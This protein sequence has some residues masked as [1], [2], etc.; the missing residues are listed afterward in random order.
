MKTRG[1]VFFL[2]AASLVLFSAQASHAQSAS[3]DYLERI[4]RPDFAV[5]DP[6]EAGFVNISN[7]NLHLEIPMASL[8]QRG[9]VPFTV[10]L[11]YDSRIYFHFPGCCTTPWNSENVI[12][13]DG[14]WKVLIT[15]QA[16][17]AFCQHFVGGS[18]LGVNRGVSSFVCYNDGI[19]IGYVYQFVDWTWATADGTS[20]SFG[21]ETDVTDI[22]FP[23]CAVFER[24]SA[25]GY[26]GDGS[27]YYMV[28]ADYDRQVAVYDNKGVLVNGGLRDTN[29]NFH[30]LDSSGNVIDTLGR[31]PVIKTVNGNITYYDILNS[32]GTRSRFTIT[33]TTINASTAFGIPYV[34]EYSGTITVVQ[35]LTLPNGQ[36]YTFTYD[37]GTTAGNYGLLQSMTL[38]TGAQIQYGYSNFNDSFCETNRWLSSR[39]SSLGGT[40]TYTPALI[41][42]GEGCPPFPNNRQDG[43]QSVT[44]VKPNHESTVYT[45]DVPAGLGAWNT[46]TVYYDSSGNALKT[47]LKEYAPVWV[48]GTTQ[49][50]IRL[51]TSFPT[52]GGSVT[53]K[54]EYSYDN[55]SYGNV[56]EVREWDYYT[57]TPPATPTRVTDATYLAA[58]QT[59]INLNILNKPTSV[60]VKDGS[61]HIFAQTNFEYDNYTSGLV[62]SGAVQH[63]ASYGPSLTARGN[64]TAIQRWRNTDGA[65]LTTRSQYDDAGNVLST[66]D[67]L[68][69]T[70]TFS[71]ADSWGNS[72]CTPTGGSAAAY[73]TQITNP[74]NQITRSKYNSCTGTQSSTTDANSQTTTYSYDAL[75]RLIQTNLAGGGQTSVCYSDTSGTSCYNG[76][77]PLKVVTTTAIATGVNLVSTAVHDALGRLSQ[78][79]L[80]SD[81]DG[82]TYVDTTYDP[83]GRKATVSNPYR[84]PNDPGPTNGVTTFLYDALGRTCLV[85]PPDSTP[86][87]G[88]SCPT[89]APANDVFTS[90]VGNT[91]TVTDQAGKKR[92]S[93]SDGLGRLTQVFEDPAGHNYETDYTYDALDNLT[94]V[95]QH[96]G[97]TGTGCASPPSSDLTSPW[98]VRRFTYN[99]LSQLKS[100]TNP[101]SNTATTPSLST[102]ATTYTYDANGNLTSKVMPAQNQ[103]GTATVTLSYCYDALNRLTSKAYTQQS[104]PMPS[105]VATYSYDQGPASANPIGRRTGMVDPAGSAGWTYDAMG[106]ALTEQRTTNNITKN[107]VYTYNLDGSVASVVYP[108]LRT[109]TYTPGGAGR[110]LAAID[111]AHSINFATNAHYSPAGALATIQNGTNLNSTYIFNN[112]LQ[113]CWMYA[114]TGTPLPLST[115]SCTTTAAAA[116]LLDLKY[117]FNLGTSDNGNVIGITNNRNNTRTQIFTYDTLNRIASARTQSTT[118]TFCWGETYTYD[119]PNSSGAWGNLISISA[120]SGYTGCP[121]ESLNVTVTPQNQIVGDTYDAAGNLINDGLGHAYTYNPENQLLTAGGVTYTYDGDGKRV[122]KSSGTLYWYGMGGDSLVETNLQGNSATEYVFFGGK[123]I[124]RRG[125][126]GGLFYYVADHLGTSRLMFQAGQTNPCYNADFYPFGGER[127][128]NGS[129]G[130]PINS[131]PQNYKF[132]GKERDSESGLDN[133]GARYDS[134]AMGRFMS[135]DPDN[136]SGQ[137]NPDDPQSWNGYSYARNNPLLYTDPNGETYEI[138]TTDPGGQKQCTSISDAQFSEA[139]RSNGEGGLFL[140][141]GD[142]TNSRSVLAAHYHDDG[143]GH[144]VWVGDYN[145]EKDCSSGTCLYWNVKTQTWE[146]P[147]QQAQAPLA[148]AAPLAIGAGCL[149]A[150]PCGA[151]A[152]GVAALF[153]VTVAAIDTYQ[154]FSKGGSNQR[155]NRQAA[156]A[157][158]AAER[159]TGKKFTQAQI[160]RFHDL[161]QKQG[162]GYR[163][164]VE[165]AVAV[166]EGRL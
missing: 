91:T 116:S 79:Q 55:Y 122:Q 153:L 68:N 62:P 134:S 71:Y 57:G 163:E 81:P 42:Q 45:F 28:V 16:D 86:P 25:A 118:G 5:I 51:T 44:V 106:R 39:T 33:K 75:A 132:T 27:G 158:R 63:L 146:S 136:I 141:N 18:C 114:T 6:V 156:D 126:L 98:R 115:T 92:K 4:G 109:I 74:L 77:N 15:G 89:T 65:W 14:G 78:T 110:P 101:E 90:Y 61:N 117:N 124:A 58:S 72:T 49:V 121:Q 12:G 105:P 165:V 112:R 31:T 83:L 120:L 102:V 104:C 36:S 56:S 52:T 80:N 166:L 2:L 164:L 97:V 73:V 53:K 111:S 47:E 41:A 64:A 95:E 20:R 148:S 22:N 23:S 123:R 1:L 37:S 88:T 48:T 60:I 162:Y 67:P 17:N 21:L 159:Q 70:T 29:G 69:H 133:F 59:Y 151:G 35:S 43:T 119:I 142:L 157:R 24:P 26:A 100:S 76:G 19:N 54:A 152:A 13:S 8:P 155:E 38:P 129:T 113:P 160:E 85:V 154:Y 139:Q 9:G 34:P 32:Q 94:C 128:A 40:W 150:E 87:S 161:I 130:Q 84:T 30:S 82:T 11:T 96:G 135:S 93:V 125:P 3:N 99:S 7:G 147:P 46:N 131:C 140:R 107:T 10:K 108:T 103:T 144:R 138:C 143:E 137:M 145:G 66:A 50:P 127:I 149:V